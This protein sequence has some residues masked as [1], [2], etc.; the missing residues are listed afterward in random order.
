MKLKKKINLII[1]III[2]LVTGIIAV[3]FIINWQQ[4]S[5]IVNKPFVQANSTSS[6]QLDLQTIIHNAQKGVVQIEA[7]NGI[8]QKVGAGFLYNHSGDIVTNAHVVE[9]AEHI[10][11]K[12]ANGHKYVGAIVEIG[13]TT[14]IAVIR[15]PELKYTE[16]LAIEDNY[17]PKIGDEIIAIGSPTG[18]QNAV[19]LGVIVG[20]DRTFSIAPFDYENVYQISANIT[21]GNS[22]GPLILKENGKVI[23]VNAAGISDTDIGFS[24]PLTTITE[25]LSNWI[26]EVDDASLVYSSQLDKNLNLEITEDD[27]KYI[28]EYFFSNITLRDYLNAYTLLSSELQSSWEYTEFRNTFISTIDVNIKEMRVTEHSDKEIHWKVESD[29]VVRNNNKDKTITQINQFV[30]GYEHDQLKIID[31]V[32]NK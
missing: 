27:A 2:S 12:L 22:G 9:D 10:I 1:A 8:Q 13:E 6:T 15:V 25:K 18:I 5:L 7:I 32:K 11:V 16:P 28:I 20:Y 24:I 26:A 17:Q 4:T 21:Y 14:D 31:Y 29:I 30:L 23:G 19:S 3:T